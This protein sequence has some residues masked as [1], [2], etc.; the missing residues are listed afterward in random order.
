MKSVLH[1]DRAATQ[2]MEK[3]VDAGMPNPAAKT[4]RA[5]IAAH[6]AAFRA[7]HRD[8]ARNPRAGTR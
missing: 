2:R 4:L 5:E 6:D 8:A 3:A 1:F 7:R